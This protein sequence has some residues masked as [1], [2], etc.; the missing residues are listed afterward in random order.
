LQKALGLLKNVD[1]VR[2]I[3]K[4]DMAEAGIGR[5]PC[6]KGTDLSSIIY[7]SGT[8]GDPLGVLLSHRNI[9]SNSRSIVK[10]SGISGRDSV[11]CV[12]PFYYI[13]GLSLLFSHFMVG[14]TVVIENGFMYPNTVLDTIEKLQTT[15]F[16]GVSSH[17][18]ML[19]GLSGLRTR[20]LPSLR[21]FMQAGDSMPPRT[22]REL[23][24]LFPKK[25]L[26]LMYGLTEASPS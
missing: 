4:S 10:Y 23:I 8:T 19:L 9:L 1:T 12:L 3:L 11:C 15:G 26:Y 14:G 25:R 22:T 24:R 17:Y 6:V 7:T 5:G 20:R 2:F 18:A 16:A 21:Y 13:Y